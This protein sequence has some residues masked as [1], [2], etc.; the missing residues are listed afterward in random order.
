MFNKF[1]ILL[2][3]ILLAGCS[4][5][6]VYT[7][8]SLDFDTLPDKRPLTVHVVEDEEEA[9]LRAEKFEQGKISANMTYDEVLVILGKPHGSHE[10]INEKGE[11]FG[12]C[13][14]Y[15][16]KSGSTYKYAIL[17]F[18]NA[19]LENINI[20]SGKK[21]KTEVYKWYKSGIFQNYTIP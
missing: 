4:S 13:T 1:V 7:R 6:L 12:G 9:K 17:T 5:P 2:V 15:L 11:S 18:R 20:T 16:G 3:I 19:I 8:S 10:R 14:Y 21:P